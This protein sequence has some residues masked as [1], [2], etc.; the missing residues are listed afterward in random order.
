MDQQS[1]QSKKGEVEFRKKLYQLQVEGEAAVNDEFK[2]EDIERLL[3]QRMQKTLV[4]MTALKKGGIASSPYLEIGAERCQRSL[5]ME[6][7]LN[8]SGAASDIS[9]YSLKSCDYYLTKFDKTKC[10]VRICCD[11]YNLPIM[12]NSLPFIF[13]YETLHHFPDPVPVLRQI[14][15]VLMPGGYFYFDEEP[16]KVILHLNL[17]TGS[18]IYSE[19]ALK[20]SRWRQVMD[21]F[22]ARPSY[23]EVEHGIIENH[24]IPVQ[25]WKQALG[26]FD[27]AKLKLHSAGNIEVNLSGP[28]NAL[29]Y[30]IAHMLGG[31]ISGICRKNGTA[32]NKPSRI[33]DTLICPACMEKG[34]ESKLEK[35]NLAFTCRGCSA[36]YPIVDGVIF[37]FTGAKF[38]EL[39]PEIYKS[40]CG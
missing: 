22:L 31:R 8:E 26:I 38:E 37:L 33:E 15:R 3:S 35:E 4:Q 39:Y 34:E 32:D 1:I 21:F 40:Y 12:T 5:V 36:K 9:Y 7:D 23:N 13:C 24:Q 16:Y 17:Y 29:N 6:N 19:E 20:S 25:K 28:H 11:V 14:N 10:P 27:D 18:K 2:K 30:F